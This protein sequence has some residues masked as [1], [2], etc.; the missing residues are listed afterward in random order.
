MSFGQFLGGKRIC[1]GKTFVDTISKI[2]GPNLLYY[3]DFEP[4]DKNILQEAPINNLDVLHEPQ[5]M[6]KILN[7]KY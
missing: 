5:V 3:F 2:V 4:V 7:A 6:I 1:L